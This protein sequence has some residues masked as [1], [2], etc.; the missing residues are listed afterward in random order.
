MLSCL[1]RCAGVGLG[2]HADTVVFCILAEQLLRWP[3]E[4]DQQSLGLPCTVCTTLP[5]TRTLFF[6]WGESSQWLCQK[7]S[8]KPADRHCLWTRTTPERCS[9]VAVLT[10]TS[11]FPDL[12][13]MLVPCLS[14]HLS[15][16]CRLVNS[17]ASARCCSCQA[18]GWLLARKDFEQAGLAW[19][20]DTDSEEHGGRYQDLRPKV[21]ISEALRCLFEV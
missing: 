2:D 14:L 4:S 1:L 19:C 12:S 3:G 7:R 15:I 20:R 6:G 18:K 17:S 9:D 13:D 11:S 5:G 8:R 10:A 21:L 16:V